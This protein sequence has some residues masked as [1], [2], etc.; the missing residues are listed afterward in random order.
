MM[1]RAAKA[2]TDALPKDHGFALMVFPLDSRDGGLRYVANASRESVLKL[3]KEF[4]EK[5][6]GSP[7]VSDADK[8]VESAK[9]L[10]KDVT[11]EKRMDLLSEMFS[12]Y[13]QAC[14]GTDSPCHCMNDD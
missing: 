12:G 4:V 13:C 8:V 3:L 11:P 14:G 7:T 1:Q 5:Q 6:Q 10:L 9:S 2:V